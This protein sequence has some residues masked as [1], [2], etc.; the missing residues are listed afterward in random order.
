MQ[1][2][3]FEPLGLRHI[4]P[5][6]V[7]AVIP[8]RAHFYTREAPGKPLE[9]AHYEDSSYKWASGGYLASAEDLVRFGS[10]HLQPGFFKQDTLDVLF[11]GYSKIPPSNRTEVGLGWNIGQDG[12]GRRILHHS[13]T[14]EGGRA[15]LLVLPDS[16]IV[17][18][19]LANIL[20]PFDIR[21]AESIGLLFDHKE[22]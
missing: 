16:G 5:D 6:H 14:S 19:M 18:A 4:A 15:V 12:Q 7:Y 2:N 1:A 20:A 17:V 13:G 21:Q 9:N 8:H 22:Q 3:V 10:A 11:T